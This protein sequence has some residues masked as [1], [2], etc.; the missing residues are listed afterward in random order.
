MVGKAF[1]G[2]SSIMFAI[3]F[4]EVR[5]MSRMEKGWE[6]GRGHHSLKHQPKALRLHAS[7]EREREAF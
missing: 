4:S 3:S 1:C 7:M 5:N 2:L 6:W